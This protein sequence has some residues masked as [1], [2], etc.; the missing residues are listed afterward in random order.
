MNEDRNIIILFVGLYTLRCS[1]V[2]LVLRGRLRGR[3]QINS[4]WMRFNSRRKRFR[5]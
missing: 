4:G 3:L 1:R 2:L 5:S